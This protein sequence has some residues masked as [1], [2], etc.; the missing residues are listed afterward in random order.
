MDNYPGREKKGFQTVEKILLS[1]KGGPNAQKHWLAVSHRHY[2]YLSASFQMP[3]VSWNNPWQNNFKITPSSLPFFPRHNSIFIA[4]SN[5]ISK[6]ACWQ[7]RADDGVCNLS[8]PLQETRQAWTQVHMHEY[9]HRHP[10]VHLLLS[11]LLLF[12]LEIAFLGCLDYFK[13]IYSLAR[14][15]Q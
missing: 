2:L 9:K 10:E 15:V 7:E 14:R 1:E 4:V 8:W 13:L 5:L 12:V 6:W 11:L 3:I